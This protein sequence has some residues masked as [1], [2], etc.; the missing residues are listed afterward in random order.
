MQIVWGLVLSAVLVSGMVA[1]A[2]AQDV[3]FSARVLAKGSKSNILILVKNSGLSN[4]SVYEFELKFTQGQPITSIA[5]GGWESDRDGNTITFTTARSE[6]KPGGTAIFL[7]RVS[8]PATSAFEWTMSDRNGNELDNGEVPKIRIRESTP[9]PIQ[10]PVTKP[11]VAVNQARVNQGGQIIVTGK[12]FSQLTSVQIFLEQRQ[13]TTSNTNAAGEFNTVVIIPSDASPGGHS[14]V[15]TDALGKS[16]LIQILVEG[17]GGQPTVP[18]GQ[19]ILTVN[20]DKTEYQPGDAV[21]I[22][23]TAIL[24]SAVSMQITDPKGGI[25]CGAN[26][27]V[28]NVSMTWSAQCFLP[29]NAPGGVYIVSAKQIVHKTAT[30]FSVVGATGGTGGTGG[31]G[32]GGEDPGNLKLATDKPS[33]RSGE[34]VKI[35][36]SG[37]RAKSIVQII[38]VGPSGPPLDAKQV[39]TDANGV[40]IYDFPLVAAQQ[41]TYKL[42]GKQDKFVVR[43]TFEVTA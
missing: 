27:Q 33:Y 9:A 29:P 5:R 26:P 20:V 25:M 42:S 13:L 28:N 4:T 23:G 39:T 14:I 30:R 2:L 43:A 17:V 37:A 18:P 24:E 19:L 1:G 8:D 32:E 10:P 31:T 36:L 21:K 38:I 41:G 40:L 16:S 7:I 3:K 11:E 22:T 15:A 35:T 12:G 34:T 6:I